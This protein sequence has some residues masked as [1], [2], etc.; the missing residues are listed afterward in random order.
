MSKKIVERRPFPILAASCDV[1]DRRGRVQ[2]TPKRYSSKNDLKTKERE[3][4]KSREK[5]CIFWQFSFKRNLR[6][7][8]F[9]QLSVY[10]TS[11]GRNYRK[12]AQEIFIWRR[13]GR[14]TYWVVGGG[15]I[16]QKTPE[17]FFRHNFIF[18]LV[19]VC[20]HQGK[21][22]KQEEKQKDPDWAETR[23]RPH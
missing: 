6:I 10:L 2:V 9:C 8:F 3:K 12:V 11:G 14:P 21:L 19:S 15:G 17:V 23:Q 5:N 4:R 1:F 7:H 13:W 20:Y 22:L 18:A 16:N